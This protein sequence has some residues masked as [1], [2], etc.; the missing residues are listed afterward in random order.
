MIHCCLLQTFFEKSFLN[1]IRSLAVK[2]HLD[3]VGKVLHP[4]ILQF[5]MFTDEFC[6]KLLEEA[7][8][9]EETQRVR[10]NVRR[11]NSMNRYGVVLDDIG[12]APLF[13]SLLKNCTNQ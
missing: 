9:F 5:R 7:R 10:G 12:F 11:P 13:D 1:A 6:E 4:G 2:K 3:L 8:H